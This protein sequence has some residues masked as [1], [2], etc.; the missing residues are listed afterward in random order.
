M[1]LKV[2]KSKYAYKEILLKTINTT[3]MPHLTQ[4]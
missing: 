4:I 3:G 2:T 1:E